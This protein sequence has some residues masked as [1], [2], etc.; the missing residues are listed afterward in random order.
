MAV[1]TL[2]PPIGEAA[3]PL[4]KAEQLAW[5]GIASAL[6]ELSTGEYIE[7]DSSPFLLESEVITMSS[8][9]SLCQCGTSRC[10][11]VSPPEASL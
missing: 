2:T 4:N 6:G 10:G 11:S 5:R 7:G 8:E 9:F 1:E 3:A